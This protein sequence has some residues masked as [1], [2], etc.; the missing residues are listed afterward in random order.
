MRIIQK[1]GDRAVKK[2][3]EGYFLLTDKQGGYLSLGSKWNV[4]HTQGLFYLDRNW[5]MYKSIDNIYLDKEMT[6]LEYGFS[7]AIRNYSHSKEKFELS[8]TCLIYDVKNYTGDIFLDLD[9]REMF[10]YDDKG[11]EYDIERKDDLVIIHY[12]KH[13][14]FLVLKGV[15]EIEVLG[16]WEKRDYHY[17][18]Q[19]N[20]KGDFYIYKALKIKCKGGLKLYISFSDNKS[21]AVRNTRSGETNEKMIKDAL[22]MRVKSACRKKRM[23]ANTAIYSLDSL[24]TTIGK[25]HHKIEGIFAGLPWFHQFWSR[26]ELISLKALMIEEKFDF[27][28]ERLMN[29]LNSI[30]EN[31]RIPNRQPGT[32]T[33]SAD[34]IGWLFKRFYDFL[35]I[36]EEKKCL[37]DYFKEEELIAVKHKLH[38]SIEEHMVKYMHDYLIKNE[39]NETWMDMGV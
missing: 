35:T 16:Q 22:N 9:F 3:G 8:P 33:S 38:Y 25:G 31:G 4:S 26:D 18:K 39:F 19:R 30:G 15:G 37:K 28:K 10:N 12:K 29:H 14:K 1:L 13:K 32:E 24:K 34:A 5:N 6:S 17:D 21:E 23:T 7:Y 20:T 27:V 2:E 11:R 36:L